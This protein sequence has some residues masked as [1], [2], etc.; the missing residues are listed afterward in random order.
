MPV[1]EVADVCEPAHAVRR[2]AA[3][4]RPR[5]RTRDAYAPAAPCARPV[6]DGDVHALVVDGAALGVRTRV[7]ERALISAAGCAGSPA[8]RGTC[9]C[10]SAGARAV[11]GSAASAGTM[12]R[13]RARFGPVSEWVQ[14]VAVSPEAL[15]CSGWLVLFARREVLSQLRTSAARR[16]KPAASVWSALPCTGLRPRLL[17]LARSDPRAHRW[18]RDRSDRAAGAGGSRLRLLLRRSEAQPRKPAGPPSHDLEPQR[19]RLGDVHPRV[20]ICVGGCDPRNPAT[21]E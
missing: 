20:G 13:G 9:R 5:S 10:T 15:V 3:A 21:E 7:E 12:A 2:G 17:S 8:S 16:R 11:R 18:E 4:A 1:P 14:S 19:S 6:A